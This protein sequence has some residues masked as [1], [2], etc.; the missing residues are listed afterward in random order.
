MTD[1]STW[2]IIIVDDEPDNIGVVQLVMQYS[3]AQVRVADN[4]FACLALMEQAVPTVLLIDIQMPGM[5][6]YELLRRIREHPVWRHVP[7]VAVT[8]HAMVGDEER[9]LSFGFDGYIPK[10][11]EAMKLAGQLKQIVD[12]AL[13]NM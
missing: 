9:I 5:T 8:A 10:P 13:G 2:D 6:G 7:A 12:N 4:G 11:I 3:G 1:L